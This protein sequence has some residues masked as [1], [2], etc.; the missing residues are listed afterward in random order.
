MLVALVGWSFRMVKSGRLVCLCTG[1]PWRR[2]LLFP[3]HFAE[4]QSRKVIQ[5]LAVPRLAG[6][7][8]VLLLSAGLT[9]ALHETRPGA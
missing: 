8:V 9:Y 6:K 4:P 7:S 2:C 5:C 1:R 3:L